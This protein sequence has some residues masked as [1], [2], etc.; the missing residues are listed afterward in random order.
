MGDFKDKHGKTRVGNILS[1]I[2]EILPTALEFA[3]DVT[4][5]EILNKASEA[6]GGVQ[7]TKREALLEELKLALELEG[8]IMKDIQDSRD[9]QKVALNQDDNFSKRFVYYLALL[10]SIAAIVFIFIGSFVEMPKENQIISNTV[11]GYIF[12][13]VSSIITY[14]FGSSAGSKLK[15]TLLNAKRGS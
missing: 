1:K 5:I 6:L 3:G 10:W 8:M 15:D 13:V 14:F 9:L 7:S 12:G 11:L 2:N 4:G